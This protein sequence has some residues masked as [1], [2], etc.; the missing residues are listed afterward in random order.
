M[1]KNIIIVVLSSAL[2][3]GG[4][5]ANSRINKLTNTVTSIAALKTTIKALHIQH[6]KAIFKTKLK[7]RGKRALALL[8]VAG[9]VAVSWFEKQEYDEWKQDNTTGTFKQ[10]INEVSGTVQEIADSYYEEIKKDLPTIEQLT[11]R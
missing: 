9:L 3:S 1:I 8:P 11:V 4:Y 7:E 10:Y 5:F 2:L 6:K